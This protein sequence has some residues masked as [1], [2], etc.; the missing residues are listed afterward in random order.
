MAWCPFATHKPLPEND[1]QSYIDPIVV[2]LHSAVDAPGPTSLFGYF[3]QESV[4]LE[5]TFFIKNDG[6]IEQYVDTNVR[7]DANRFANPFAISIETEDDG[8]PDNRPWTEAQ[9]RSIKL[10]IEWLIEVHPKIKRRVAPAWNAAGVGYHTMWGAPSEWTPVSKSCPGRVR[11]DQF[12][13]DIAPWLEHGEPTPTPVPEEDDDMR[14]IRAT[15]KPDGL[16]S[17]DAF[18]K[19]RD[20]ASVK[21]FTDSGVKVVVV[22][23]RDYD[24]I[25]KETP[26]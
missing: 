2:I 25:N 12:W 24:A 17:G 6:E 20:S 21:A 5:S 9:M 14:I 11:I 13:V 4:K 26:V 22:T 7:A 23:P 10:L 3:E 18:I 15:G 16:L 8:D 1:T 19:L